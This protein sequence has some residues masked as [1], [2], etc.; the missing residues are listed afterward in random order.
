VTEDRPPAR[1]V[2]LDTSVPLLAMGGRHPSREA[3][4]RVLRLIRDGELD[5]IASTEMIQEFVFHRLRRNSDPVAA[6]SEG[7]DLAELVHVAP[8][9]AAALQESLRLVQSGQAR[10]RDAVHAATALRLGVGVIVSADPDFDSV[11]GLTRVDPV[12]IP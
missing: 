12:D 10:G 2:L 7:R 4:Q 1:R 6:A 8:F 11:V 9:D 3:S 5:A